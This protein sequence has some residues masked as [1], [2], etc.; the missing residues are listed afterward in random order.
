[1]NKNTRDNSYYFQNQLK[2][3]QKVNKKHNRA[4]SPIKSNIEGC[5]RKKYELKKEK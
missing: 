3:I 1:M 4:H 2:I 5:I